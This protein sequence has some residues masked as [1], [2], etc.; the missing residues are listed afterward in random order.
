RGLDWRT[1]YPIIKGICEGL[2]YLHQQNIVHLDL[3]PANILLDSK[4]VPRIADFGLAKCFDEKQTRAITSKVVG[5]Q[6]YM[7]PES[8][9]GVITYKADI[10][11]LGVII[12]EMLT[13]QKGYLQIENV[14]ERWSARFQPLEGG[15]WLEHVRVC[16]EI[17]LKCINPNPVE[18]PLTGYIIE[19]LAEMEQ[20]YDFFQ[21]DVCTTPATYGIASTNTVDGHGNQANQQQCSFELGPPRGHPRL[22]GDHQVQAPSRMDIAKNALIIEITI[23]TLAH[24]LGQMHVSEEQPRFII[25]AFIIIS[26]AALLGYELFSKPVCFLSREEYLL[27][28]R[29]ALREIL[30]AQIHLM[31]SMWE[32]MVDTE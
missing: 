31:V 5:S 4:L 8:Y 30:T 17:G 9:D 32:N 3:K 16:A 1:C 28:I 25:V 29:H 24:Q 27:P 13:G 7:A 2:H 14:L 20:R 15:N 26:I 10:Y 6:G 22:L 19:T 21:T 23:I 18:R 12:T 11:S